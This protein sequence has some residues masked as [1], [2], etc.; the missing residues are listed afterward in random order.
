[1]NVPARF[2]FFF[3]AF[4]TSLYYYNHFT[5]SSIGLNRTAVFLETYAGIPLR[6]ATLELLGPEKFLVLVGTYH[7]TGL[8]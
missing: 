4:P 2:L 6:Y 3:P 8:N 5:F 1:M 7:L